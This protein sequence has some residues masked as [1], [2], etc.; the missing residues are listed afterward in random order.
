[1]PFTHLHV[2]TEYSML[3]GLSRIERLVDRAK[4][5][6]M[7]ALSITDHGGMY[8]VVDFYSACKAAGIKPLIGCEM[9]VAP[10][11]LHDKRS[12][13]KNPYHLTVLAQNNQGYKNL[14]KMVTKSNLEGFYYKPRIDK[15]LLAQ[16]ADGLIVLSGCPSAEL[17]RLVINGDKNGAEELVRWYKD[18]VPNFYL[19]IQRH[20]NLDFL[21]GLNNG[22]L[23][24][25]EKMDV[26]LVATNDL[27]YVKQEEAPLQDVMVCIQTNTTLNDESRMKMSDE[28]YYLKGPE[29]MAE[30]FA[31]LPEAIENTQKIADSCDMTLDFSTL[32]LPQYHVPTDE[33]ADTYLR[34]LCWEGFESRFP[35]GGTEE[36]KQRLGYE[37]DVITKTRYP[38]YFLVVWDIADFARQKAIVFGVRGSAA[39][40][41]ALYCLGVTEIDPLAYS[42]VFERFLNIERKEMPDIDMDFQ[43]DRREEAIKYVVAKYG[44]DHVAQIITFGTMGAKAAIRDSGRALGMPLVDVDRMARLVPTAVGMTLQTA[45]DGSDE[46]KEAYKDP[47]LKR[48]LDTAFGLEGVVRHASTHAAGVLIS[49]D[50]LTEVVPLQRPTKGDESSTA[51]TQYAM[52]PVAKLGLLK[53]DFLGLINYSILS[54]AQKKILANH[55]VDIRLHDIPFNDQTTYD[56]L[57]SGETTAIFQLESSGMRRHIKD[58]RPGSLAELAAMVALYRP[59]P[60]EHIGTYIDSKH[61]KVP[62]KYPHPALEQILQETYGIIVYQ[63]QVLHILRTFAG[64]S[65]G[66]ADIVRKAM[67]KKIASL[68]QEERQKF[69]AGAASL[70][71][72]ERTAGP[73]FDLIEPF[74]GYAFNK[75]HSVSYAVVAYWTAYFKAN[76]PVEFMTCVL[77]AYDGNAEKASAVIDECK[78]LDIPVLPPDVSRSDVEFEVDQAD[79]GKPAIRFGLASIKNVGPGAVKDLVAERKENGAFTTLEDFARRAGSEAASRRVLESLAKVGAMDAFGHRG[80]LL[81]SLDSIANLIQQEAKLKDSGQSTMFDLFGQ[82]MPTPLAEIELIESTEPT[83]RE[84]A[85][86]ERELLGVSLSEADLTALF[87]NAP[88]GTVLSRIDLPE[89]EGTKVRLVGQIAS[90][91]FT[92]NKQQQR[93]AFIV[94]TLQSGSVDVGIN[95]R[96]YPE[97]S[98]LWVEGEFVI[99]DGRVSRGRDEELMVWCDRAEPYEL[100]A[101]L[102]SLESSASPEVTAPKMEEIPTLPDSPP[103]YVSSIEAAPTEAVI[104]AVVSEAV[105]PRS[106]STATIRPDVPTPPPVIAA[107]TETPSALATVGSPATTAPIVPVPYGGNQRKLLVNLTETNSPDEDA[108]LL[109]SVLQTL[110]DYPG[111][112]RVELLISSDGKHWR[113]EMPIITTGY[114]QDLE[115]RLAGLLGRPDGVTLLGFPAPAMA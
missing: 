57:A 33:D 91:R 112:D 107:G 25:A 85:A 43:D 66:E 64:Y 95:S 101:E 2:H 13:D 79:D 46:M 70:G 67:G 32:H 14:I 49:E 77:N 28:S 36:A 7:E 24:L 56:L 74:A 35:Q 105:P 98:D 103:A 30:L 92:L 82:S 50:P 59:G 8:G 58:L 44:A 80:Q 106:P 54:N 52:E 23:T 41:L 42:L 21:E 72:D 53:M 100:P 102:P 39:S 62:I 113:L 15:E 65:L 17:S 16:H 81:A 86:W 29:E 12:I 38:N 26:P 1:M 4:E 114:C 18:S 10:E 31:D 61:G 99:V 11:S 19:E 9:Y 75:A 110:L 78:R 83:K 89:A 97:T 96:A 37:L 5:L 51:M 84:M 48:L 34:R 60:M 6:R 69:L 45:M 71:Y 47:K 68:M 88:E 55:G 73:I 87:R 63:D 115:G 94:L 3:D 20:E 27:H 109:R 76:F 93:M 108:Y 104:D 90:V 22:L 40:S 111:T